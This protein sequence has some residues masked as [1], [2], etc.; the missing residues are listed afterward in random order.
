MNR[1]TL[2]WRRFGRR[3]FGLLLAGALL[4]GARPS[5]AADLPAPAR[6]I[7][8]LNAALLAAMKAGPTEA[9]AARA[10]ALK[11]V[12]ERTFDLPAILR[13][14]IG[15]R[16]AGFSAVAQGALL[17]AFTDF[18]VASWAANFDT[19]DGERFEVLPEM[20]QVGA[21][22][23]VESRIV[24]RQGA[25]T[26]LDYVMRE[27]DG[28]WKAVDV[29]VDGAISRVATQRS[30]FRSL[31]TSGDPTPLLDML[32]RKAGALAADGGS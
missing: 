22:Q 15:A 1:A 32:R 23:V 25:P 13:A 20:R 24:P 19:Y 11:P 7:A 4:A 26:R 31:L 12:V 18:T 17:Q 16:W 5:V 27:T 10:Q 29:L 2:G 21:D 6:P 14:S 9:F 28:A 3:G 8:A 30:D